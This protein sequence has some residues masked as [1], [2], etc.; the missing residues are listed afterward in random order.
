MASRHIYRPWD[1]PRVV[2]SALTGYAWK[3]QAFAVSGVA[4]ATGAGSLSP[5]GTYTSTFDAWTAAFYL[6][7]GAPTGLP[8]AL[9]E[10]KLSSAGILGYNIGS[11]KYAGDYAYSL[12]TG[13]TWPS[14][15]KFAGNN[16]A[17]TSLEFSGAN[18]LAKIYEQAA[19]T[20]THVAAPSG[21]ATS[22]QLGLRRI[23]EG[24]LGSPVPQTMSRCADLADYSYQ[25]S[26]PVDVIPNGSGRL[27]T[28]TGN[29]A[30]HFGIRNKNRSFAQCFSPASNWIAVRYWQLSNTA[31]GL[32]YGWWESSTGERL[33]GGSTSI[34][35]SNTP[36]WT[37]GATVIWSPS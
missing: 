33:Y 12:A 28:T 7:S 10:Y 31:T 24:A 19:P 2:S 18:R 5:T 6:G 27:P 23:E 35:S 11:F 1:R 22:G 3:H 34:H 29:L 36:K 30:V 15:S 17:A 21:Y 4:D 26:M 25:S 20:R 32:L 14:A 9:T 13:L 16:R 8:T 37:D